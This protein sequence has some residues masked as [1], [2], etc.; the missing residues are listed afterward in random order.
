[1]PSPIFTT[2]LSIL[3]SYL[4]Y[5]VIRTYY[6]L[7][8][9]PGPFWARFSNLPRVSWVKTMR[10]H[11]IHQELHR[12]YGNVVR[13]GPNMVSIA[14]PDAIPVVYPPRAGFPKS[15]F[16]RA[17]IPHTPTGTPL[18]A[19]FTTQDEAQHKQLKS[20]IAP[21]YSLSNTTTLEPFVDQ[22]LRLLTSELDKRFTNKKQ[23]FDL[24]DW[25]QYFAFE[26]MGTMTFSKRY[27]LL[28][29]GRD[30][31]GMLG[32]IWG[33][34]LG[35]APMTQIPWLDRLWNKSR[36]TALLKSPAAASPILK[37]VAD[38]ISQ[39]KTLREEESALTAETE[40]GAGSK[41]KS[42]FSTKSHKDF[43]DQFLDLQ[44]AN[45]NVQ[46]WYI[47]A[48]TFSNVIAGSDSTASVMKSI[49]YNLISH[50][51]TLQKLHD[52]LTHNLPS[53]S[54][55]PSPR[56]NPSSPTTTP[57]PI[58]TTTT[59]TPHSPTED[60]HLPQWKHLTPL[61]YL[62]AVINEGIRL[63]PPFCLA[64]ERVVPAPGMTICGVWVPGGTV[65]G[66]NPFVVN[67]DEAV[68]GPDGGV[69]RPER[70]LEGEEGDLGL[71]EGTRERRRRRRRR[72]EGSVLTFG[73]GRRV[74]MG[75]HVALLEI[76]KIVPALVLNYEFHM[77]DP[78]SYTAENSYF[79]RQKGID[80]EIRRRGFDV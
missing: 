49:M 34:M 38:A 51:T 56:P 45:R 48:W 12:K 44:E 64:L 39:R 25:L 67:R 31:N 32:A 10:A 23:L 21:I 80:V 37:I 58:T 20:P 59:T 60:L 76:Q 24:G 11:E 15:K 46:P 6:R 43:L 27:G 53:P 40:T 28:E 70:W 30:V 2:L 66:M 9:I 8:H 77:P 18:P 33:F 69:W 26:T 41:A 7:A 68:F 65:V 52:E 4:L 16:Y 74:C 17:F 3:I 35:V 19:I 47:Q 54:P 72:M 29:E 78:A 75:K 13:M 1:M 63:H 36:L 5:H 73:A 50:P 57:S 55:S 61:P 14:D 79:F 42:D 22:T 71:G 62:D